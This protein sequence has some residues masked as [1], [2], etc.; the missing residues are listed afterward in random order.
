M[1]KTG[2]IRQSEKSKGFGII[3]TL[4]QRNINALSRYLP[5]YPSVRA[6]LQKNRGVK[7]GKNVFIGADVMIDEVFP[8]NIIIEDDVTIIA[9]S[10]ILSHAFYPTH[11]GKTIH[12]I[13]STTKIKKG[14]YV[15]LGS[16]ILPGVTIGCYSIIGA[17][18][19]VTKDVPDYT[20]VYGNPAKVQGHI[21]KCLRRIPQNRQSYVCPNCKR[22]Y[23]TKG[24]IMQEIK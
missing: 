16:T 9:R 23:K 2:R 18:S 7:I 21:C 13:K 3:Q 24:G 12:D 4:W 5:M 1:S 15:G 20:I 17:G 6:A 14:S 22:K 8:E 11:F 19:L 10:S